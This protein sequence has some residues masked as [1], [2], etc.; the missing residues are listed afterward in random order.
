MR[1]RS[2]G[3]EVQKPQVS[4]MPKAS[5]RSMPTAMYQRSRSGGTGAAPV[6]AVLMF[7]RPRKLRR[8]DNTSFCSTA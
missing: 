5:S 1:I 6:M 3:I 7:C 2:G 8:F 4:V